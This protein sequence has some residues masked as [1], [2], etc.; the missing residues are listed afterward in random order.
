MLLF[1]ASFASLFHHLKR[2]SIHTRYFIQHLPKNSIYL[3]HTIGF[4]LKRK[5]SR[6]SSTKKLF[7]K[8][9]MY[10]NDSHLFMCGPYR[11]IPLLD[12]EMMKKRFLQQCEGWFACV[13]MAKKG[14]RLVVKECLIVSMR[15]PLIC[16]FLTTEAEGRP[17]YEKC[18]RMN[19]TIFTMV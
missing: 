5:F 2:S 16:K 8:C 4:S 3:F 11:L 1:R 19:F 13:Q 9:W 17:L 10:V 18:L 7:L 12:F 14:R 15:K 6:N